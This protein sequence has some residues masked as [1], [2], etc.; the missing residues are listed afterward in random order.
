LVAE[1]N[2]THFIDMPSRTFKR[3][4]VIGCH[5]SDALIC[6]LQLSSRFLRE[7]NLDIKTKI[8]VRFQ[9]KSNWHESE[10]ANSEKK[11]RCFETRDHNIL[12]LRWRFFLPD[13]S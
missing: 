10:C 5:H 1:I 6:R 7:R 3:I 4:T 2:H 11:M 8:F 12:R 9:S 13:L